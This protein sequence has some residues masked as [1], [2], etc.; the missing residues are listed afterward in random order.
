MANFLAFDLGASSGRA[1]LGR[2][3]GVS[4]QMQ[5]VHR[6]K[7]QPVMLAGHYYWDVFRLFH[8]IKHAL[9]LYAREIAEPLE[10]I[11]IDGWGADFGL[12]GPGGELVGAPYHYR[13]GRTRGMVKKASARMPAEEIY[14]KTGISFEFFNTLNQLLAMEDSPHLLQ[15]A[16][17][18]LFLP[19]LLAYY[20]TGV[21]KTEFCEA[22]TSQLV[23]P[24]EKTWAFDVIKNMG[25]PGHLFPEMDFPGAVRGRLL[26]AIQKETGLGP[27]PVY[28][29]ASHDTSAASAAVPAKGADWAFLSSGTWSLLGVEVEKPIITRESFLANYTNEGAA[30]GRFNFMKNIM[31]L[32]IIQQLREDWLREGEDY[33]FR[34]MIAAA[35]EAPPFRHFI[36]PDDPLFIAPAHMAGRIRA[37]C[38]KTGQPVPET[39][40]ELVRCGYESLALKYR[41]ALE[42]LESI[43]GKRYKELYI[44][45]GGAKNF[46]LNRFTASAIGR[47][48]VAG[49]VEATAI[50]NLLMQAMAA[51]RLKG[52]AALRGI[53]AE[54]FPVQTYLPENKEEWAEAY[55]RFCQ[56]TLCRKP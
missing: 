5:E 49:P 46:M 52:L 1:I 27:V 56:V 30:G 19:D 41:M 48:V 3:N 9:C 36:D 43:T 55:K 44:V 15:A 38:R 37:Y 47:P 8:E 20:L 7:N 18:L 23:N 13:D 40:G 32:W 22:A 50:G 35:E 2:F 26:P 39:H 10:G 33:P 34:R 17:K 53:V 54:S 14:K 6:F 12:V 4:L 29:I 28:V 45:G 31:G 25:I 42:G 16:S 24:F 11:A 21:Q 51:G